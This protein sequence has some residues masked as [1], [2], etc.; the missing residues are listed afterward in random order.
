MSR[1]RDTI[2][3]GFIGH[4]AERALEFAGR[5]RF[6]TN[7]RKVKIAPDPGEEDRQNQQQ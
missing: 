3:L 2:G 5:D 6:E 4:S 1:D 7:D